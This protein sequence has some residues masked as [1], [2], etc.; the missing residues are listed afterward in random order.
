[1][2]DKSNVE[3][4]KSAEEALKESE[5]KYRSLFENM[6]N[7][8]AYCRMIFDE[9]GR[10]SD[11]V[12]LEVND[13][14]EKLTGL[15]KENVLG[16]RITEILPEVKQTNPEIFEVYGDVVLS[17]QGRR[18]EIFFVPLNIW[19]NIS[20]YRPKKDHFAA[21]FENI[22]ERKVAEENLRKSEELL[23]T[24]MD[25]A[26]DAILLKDKTGRIFFANAEALRM[27]GKPIWEVV[28]KTDMELFA[29]AI[30]S[31]TIMDADRKAMESKKPVVLEEMIPTPYGKRIVLATK[32]PWLTE[33]G[34]VKGLIVMARDITERKEMEKTLSDY[35]QR[36][37]AVVAQRTAEYVQA[38]ERLTRELD[39][40]QKMEAALK[41]R[42]LIL[43]HAREA[44]LLINQKGDFVY[45]NEAA[46]ALYG[47]SQNE[48]LN[49]N[50]SQLRRPEETENMELSLKKIVEEGH[51][52]HNVTHVRKDGSLVQVRAVHSMV[53]TEH[54]HFIISIM[55]RRDREQT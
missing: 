27:L 3:E 5:E 36:L 22:T 53:K 20:V 17:G 48:F 41:L 18:F 25:D 49:M 2:V 23:R 15:K 26:K 8:F 52:E 28:G 1:M 33:E 10:P 43:D 51:L 14:F 6:L 7:G 47:Y 29:E 11:L 13:A 54:G 50:I 19:L 37:E 34:E 55:L 16:K 9:A 39:E 32:S 24:I 46:S 42:A 45:A 4:G 21:I 40:Y 12:Y 30:V 38:N 31:K 44:I 35:N